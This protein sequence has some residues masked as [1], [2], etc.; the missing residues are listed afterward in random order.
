MRCPVEWIGVDS[1]L[2]AGEQLECAGTSLEAHAGLGAA[3]SLGVPPGYGRV[4]TDEFA[5]R[6][7]E[8]ADTWADGVT[9]S[10]VCVP[11]PGVINE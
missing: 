9:E 11:G 10:N 5:I 8:Q 6:M 3:A 4:D 7:G 1:P 2:N